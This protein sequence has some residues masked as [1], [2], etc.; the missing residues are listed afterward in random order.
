MKERVMTG[1][2]VFL[3]LLFAFLTRIFT[4]YIFDAL[5]VA[6][7]VI[8]AYESS[9]LFAKMGYYNSLLATMLYPIVM[10]TTLIICIIEQ[11]WIVHALLYQFAILFSFMIILFLVFILAKNSTENEIKTRKFKGKKFSF[12][13]QKTI[14]TMIAMLYPT[15]LVVNFIVLNH[16]DQIGLIT[17]TENANLF[18]I[19]ALVL[20]FAIPICTDIFSM[21]TGMLI[22]GK[23]LFPRISPKKTI[24]GAIGGLIFTLL[25]LL[26]LY[27]F[28]G[29][30]A[31]FEQLFLTISFKVYHVTILSIL[32]TVVA[33]GGDLFESY[34]KRKAD[35]KDSGNFLPGHGG[36]LDRIDSHAF[37]APFV[38]LFFVFLLL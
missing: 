4:L 28:V 13:L 19:C 36:V 8:G 3:F 5:V 10:A 37:C 30:F 9:K 35:V 6:L 23:K 22:G 14:H 18:S 12:A 32:G 24:A 2:M 29:A 17:L 20:A 21:L 34:L 38:L 11:V 16:I 1:V 25:I 31:S 33:I 7:C 26:S 15:A 27:F